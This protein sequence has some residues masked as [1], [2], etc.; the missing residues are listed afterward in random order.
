MPVSAERLTNAVSTLS[1]I[2]RGKRIL[3][4]LHPVIREACGYLDNAYMPALFTVFQAMTENQLNGTLRDL[5]R[6]A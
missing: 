2:D 4:L 5:T 6:Q 1:E 3:A